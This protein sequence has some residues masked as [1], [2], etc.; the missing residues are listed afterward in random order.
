MGVVA[1][2]RDHFRQYEVV[3]CESALS[4]AYRGVMNMG[5]RGGR[6]SLQVRV[7]GPLVVRVDDRDLTPTAAKQRVLLALLALNANSFVS[8]DRIVATLW[9]SVPPRSAKSAL[10]GYVTAVRRALAPEQRSV[11]PSRERARGGTALITQ[12]AGYL[13]R[14]DSH[15]LDLI[16]FRDLARAGRAALAA[17]DFELAEER[18]VAALRLWS[19]T[20]LADL[21]QVPALDG[22]AAGLAEECTQLVHDWADALLGQGK[23][24]EA[25][26]RLEDLCARHPLRE[27]CH[28]QLML[29][30][31]QA[32]R[33]ADALAVYARAYRILTTEAG[34]E[35]CSRLREA[36]RGLLAAEPEIDRWSDTPRVAVYPGRR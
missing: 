34:I 16:A 2:F 22:H 15:E 24:A 28:Y 26:G 5:L 12:P 19:G 33:R 29:A 27:R 30:L 31:H 35:P 25:V 1:I 11:V 32:D 4:C 14:L 3:Q 36:H 10:H 7:L 9:E 13:L 20:P 8:T 23:G 17:A 21:Q 18:F 6:P